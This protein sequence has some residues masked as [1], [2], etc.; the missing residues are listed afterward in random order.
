MDF[1][2]IRKQKR[3]VDKKNKIFTIF[4]ARAEKTI[5]FKTHWTFLKFFTRKF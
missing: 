5:I 2:K 1:F 3:S 4:Q